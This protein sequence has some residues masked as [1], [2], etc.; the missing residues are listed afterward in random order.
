[1]LY[2]GIFT[3]WFN[4]ASP[5]IVAA[6]KSKV[7]ALKSLGATVKEITIPNLRAINLATNI[8]ITTELVAGFDQIYSKVVELFIL[9]R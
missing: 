1:M 6:C 7:E 3:D 8:I 4:D 2:I 9:S 5:E